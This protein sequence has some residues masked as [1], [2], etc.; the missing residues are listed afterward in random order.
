LHYTTAAA[1]AHI[2]LTLGLDNHARV[3]LK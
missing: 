3:F 1:A 2:S